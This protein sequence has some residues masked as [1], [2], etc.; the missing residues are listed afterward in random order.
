VAVQKGDRRTGFV[1]DASTHTAGME[2]WAEAVRWATGLVDNPV[3][4][5][6]VGKTRLRYHSVPREELRSRGSDSPD[7]GVC[8]G[9]VVLGVL[10]AGVARGL[11][12]PH[13]RD[14]GSGRRSGALG[15][16]GARSRGRSES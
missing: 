8:Q 2:G 16:W 9:Q 11:L 14:F 15:L 13:Q 4:V 10:P 6:Q 3:P 12:A 7:G 5:I 1:A